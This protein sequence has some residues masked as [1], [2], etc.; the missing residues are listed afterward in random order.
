M[1]ARGRKSFNR[2]WKKGGTQVGDKRHHMHSSGKA[3]DLIGAEETKRNGGE[4]GKCWWSSVAEHDYLGGRMAKS[5][6]KV[7]AP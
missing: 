5:G 4:A 1:S 7:R 2:Y 6:K 3:D